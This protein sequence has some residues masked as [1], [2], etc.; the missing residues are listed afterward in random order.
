MLYYHGSPKVGLTI[1]KPF[2]CADSNLKKPCVYL[3]SNRALAALYIWNRPFRWM[4]YGIREDGVPVY[5]ESFPGALSTFYSGVRGCVYTCRGNYTENGTGISVAVVSEEPVPVE[6]TE[7]IDDAYKELLRLEDAGELV[8]RRYESLSEEQ[9]EAQ[10]TM[11]LREI[12]EENL[13]RRPESPLSLFLQERFPTLW[14]R[15]KKQML[16]EAPK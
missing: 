10:N 9:L 8:I 13:L 4:N 2:L 3:T 12:R 1:L 14:E 5:T 11:I 15:A 16:S 6:A 7:P